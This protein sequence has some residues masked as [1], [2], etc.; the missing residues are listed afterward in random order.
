[1]QA[2]PMHQAQR[3]SLRT[4]YPFSPSLFASPQAHLHLPALLATPFLGQM[5]GRPAR[6]SVRLR[7]GPEL[8]TWGLVKLEREGDEGAGG[9]V[10]AGEG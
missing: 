7:G 1:M 3:R 5:L 10:S 6:L 4:F 8:S 9:W 2:L